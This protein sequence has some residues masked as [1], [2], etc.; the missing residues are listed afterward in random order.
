LRAPHFDDGWVVNQDSAVDARGGALLMVAMEVD[1]NE[2]VRASSK[3]IK[4]N[5]K[6]RKKEKRTVSKHVLILAIES[7]RSKHDKKS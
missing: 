7:A 2:V 5:V 6:R 4:N 3:E 1:N